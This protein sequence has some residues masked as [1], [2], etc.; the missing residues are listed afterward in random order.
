[1]E[2]ASGLEPENRG[3]AELG[4]TSDQQDHS[5]LSVQYLQLT[6]S[7]GA[8]VVPICRIRTHGPSQARV[9]QTHG[10]LFTAFLP[11][12]RLRLPDLGTGLNRCLVPSAGEG[13]PDPS[14]R[15]GAR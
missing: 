7:G 3:F 14:R 10:A 1:M 8:S 9:K 15:I 13:S 2:A 6:A 4:A 12:R 5:A 11:T